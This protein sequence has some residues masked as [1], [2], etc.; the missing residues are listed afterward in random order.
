MLLIAAS[1]FSDMTLDSS[2]AAGL[3]FSNIVSSSVA[4]TLTLA[5]PSVLAVA[6]ALELELGDVKFNS[7][8]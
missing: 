4:L 1:I 8:S 5:M 3:S 7:F 6:L 2:V